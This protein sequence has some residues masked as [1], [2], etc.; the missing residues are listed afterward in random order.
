MSGTMNN[1]KIFI[2]LAT[3]AAVLQTGCQTVP[4]GHA[5]GYPGYGGQNTYGNVNPYNVQPAA[6]PAPAGASPYAAPMAAA[7]GNY[8]QQQ[9]VEAADNALKE[10]LER[11]EKAMLRLD[12]RMQLVERG[13]LSR[14]SSGAGPDQ[15][16]S[17]SVPAP[18]AQRSYTAEEDQTAMNQLEIGPAQGGAAQS[19]GE[20]E[21][22]RVAAQV[23]DSSYQGDF[24]PVSADTTIRSPLQAAP[25]RQLASLADTSPAAGRK[26]QAASDVAV[27]TVRYD[28]DKVWPDR[29][30]L[31]LSRDVVEAL[32]AGSNNVT[33]FARGPNPNG[34]QFRERVKAL[35]R[36]LA[37]VT[38]Q[39]T[40]PIAALPSPQMD[41]NTI[42]ILATH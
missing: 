6:G 1:N 34:T 11:V 17:L 18:T 3:V 27:W 15:H 39:D 31:P 41:A 25:P 10:R 38:S 40:V 21:V 28:A 12:R 24:R 22:T 23:D 4:S 26:P 30:Q 7:Y 36:Y 32:R 35:S 2:G 5:G 9:S 13:E 14:M 42:E 20:T 29:A 16:A 19:R 8:A 33:L 37:K